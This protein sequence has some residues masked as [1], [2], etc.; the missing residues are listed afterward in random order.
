MF[1]FWWLRGIARNT[2][3][4]ARNTAR[5]TDKALPGAALINGVSVFIG[6]FVAALL[7]ALF[8]SWTNRNGFA[9]MLGYGLGLLCGLGFNAWMVAGVK[10]LQH[11]AKVN[12]TRRER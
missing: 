7:A 1:R 11:V 2:G 4:I 10:N 9:T 6:L 5:A 3:K 8:A 12:R